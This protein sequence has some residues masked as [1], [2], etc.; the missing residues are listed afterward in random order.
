MATGCPRKIK[1]KP[2]I[3][4]KKE[5]YDEIQSATE[6]YRNFY[7][8]KAKVAR[9]H[10]SARDALLECDGRIPQYVKPLIKTRKELEDEIQSASST[11]TLYS[12]EANVARVGLHGSTKE[13]L[14]KR[15]G[16]KRK[17]K[18]FWSDSN[19]PVDER[20]MNSG[21]KLAKIFCTRQIKMQTAHD[22][23][24]QLLSSEYSKTR[25][26][27][28]GSSS[29]TTSVTEKGIVYLRIYKPI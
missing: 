28:K 15:E 29:D 3:R 11:S 18:K 10:G 9:A 16:R 7:I 4:T 12:S 24:L 13:A 20:A 17:Q 19:H 25:L 22:L 2:Q 5:I 21:L 14:H 6:N 27:I 26:H 8:G 1:V 23:C